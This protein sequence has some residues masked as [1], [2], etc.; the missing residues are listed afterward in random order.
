ME[1]QTSKMLT[2]TEDKTGTG[3]IDSRTKD[4]VFV[5]EFLPHSD[6]LFNFALRL[7]YERHDAND[8]VQDTYL[9]AYRF[10]GSF[11]RG[12]NAKAWLFRILKNTFINEFRRKSKEPAKVDYN[13][14]ESFVN[15]DDVV[16]PMASLKTE[17]KQHLIGDEIANALNSLAID[18]RTILILSDLEGFK[19]EEMAKILD[20]PI[21]TVRSRLHRARHLLKGK[22]ESYAKKKG[23]A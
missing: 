4:T 23:Y 20:I 6:A 16:S 9:K 19:Y 11:Q 1:S 18:F 21:G 8:L 13:E 14:V 10:V 2:F 12:T 22:L 15:V 5:N 7:T 17:N 3:N